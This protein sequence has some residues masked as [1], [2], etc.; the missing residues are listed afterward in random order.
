MQTIIVVSIGR[1]IGSEPMGDTRWLSFKG[2]LLETVR[3]LAVDIL[4][5]P[6]MLP[7]GPDADTQVGCWQGVACE[8]SALVMAIID[9]VNLPRLSGLLSVLA[10]QYQQDAIGL[11]VHNNGT[12]T[13]CHAR[14]ALA[15]V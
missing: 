2:D 12:D 11:I 8:G 14:H 6:L 10:A 7:I 9:P 5:R 1:C 4:Q 3:G 15:D 13:L